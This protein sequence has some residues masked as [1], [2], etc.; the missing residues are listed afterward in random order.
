L[1]KKHKKHKKQEFKRP[2]TKRQLSS[3][4]RQK[5]TQ[6]II[7]I[8]SVVFLA[9]VIG[10]IGYGYYNNQ[11]K[12]FHQPVTRVNDTVVDTGYYVKM[13]DNYSRGYDAAMLPA[14]SDVV[15]E[16]IQRTELTKQGAAD[17]GIYINDEEIDKELNN[18]NLP[19]D[20]M[21]R[22]ALKAE[23][24][25]ARLLEEHFD[26]SVPTADEQVQVQAMFLESKEVAEEMIAKLE[27]GSDFNSLAKEF[28]V[29]SM[30][31]GNEGDI[32]WLPKGS[33]DIMLERLGDSLLK[34]IVF[35]LD[36][37]ILTEP[38]YDESIKKGVGYWLIETIER[39]GSTSSHARGILLGSRRE[40]EEIRAKLEAGEDF[41]A[42]AGEY[43]QDAG[44]KDMDGDLG[45]LQKEVGNK[46]VNEIA[47]QLEIGVLSEP[48]RDKIVQTQGGYWVIKIIDKEAN[49]QLD[50]EARDKLKSKVFEDWL[51]E[52]K[53]KSFIENYLDEEQR[54]WA[55][56]QV[57]E[58]RKE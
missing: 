22:D 41:A 57:L 43:S 4:E 28:S 52:Q 17:L 50:N 21:Y 20:E 45:W 31:K 48:I 44:S 49:R 16:I 35:D 6:R 39:E 26:S 58:G 15:I 30:T 18:R 34:D 7:T 25:T 8:A 38:I 1:A 40:A 14:W 5:R 54:S 10:F 55:V 33:A 24:L 12:P 36:P 47:F 13:L 9:F 23:L 29:E 11:V 53:E 2:P 19:D 42:L 51:I 3:W 27:A 37:G 46:L 56:A 32:G